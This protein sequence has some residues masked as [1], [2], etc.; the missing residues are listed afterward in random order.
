[1]GCLFW[2]GLHSEEHGDITE[3]SWGAAKPSNSRKTLAAAHAGHSGTLYVFYMYV[4]T[5]EV[6][7]IVNPFTIP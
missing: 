1:M 6:K 5:V 4:C 2:S 7:N 3:G